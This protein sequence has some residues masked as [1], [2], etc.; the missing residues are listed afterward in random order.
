MQVRVWVHMLIVS[1]LFCFA[2]ACAG[3]HLPEP[4][5][6]D[7]ARTGVS[8]DVLQRGRTAYQ[9]NCGNC[10]ALVAPSKYDQRQWPQKVD[11]MQERAGISDVARADILQYLSAYAEQTRDG[12]NA[13]R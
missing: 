13:G 10:H 5:A 1:A 7:A 8:L 6:A 2:T 11:A 12:A 3:V 9:S 4:L